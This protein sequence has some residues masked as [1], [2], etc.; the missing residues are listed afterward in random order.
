MVL[1]FGPTRIEGGPEQRIPA[2]TKL[3][4]HASVKELTPDIGI[5]SRE[6][7]LNGHFYGWLISRSFPRHAW[8]KE[9]ERTI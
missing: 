1:G 6:L 5:D 4:Q 7:R 2:N 9:I 8:E 3:S